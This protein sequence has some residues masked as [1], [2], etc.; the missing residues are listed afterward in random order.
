MYKCSISIKLN[1]KTLYWNNFNTKQ[2][3][4]ICRILPFNKLNWTKYQLVKLITTRVVLK[5]ALLFKLKASKKK[6]FIV[7]TKS[8]IDDLKVCKNIKEKTI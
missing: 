4:N 5:F 3:L 6:Y 2:H 7:I 1:K 8:I